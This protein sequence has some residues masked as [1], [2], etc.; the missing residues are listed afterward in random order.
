MKKASNREEPN[1]RPQEFFSA[2][3]HLTTV[4]QLLPKYYKPLIFFPRFAP[5]RPPVHWS[6]IRE[7]TSHG[8]VCPQTFPM[9][10]ANA[11]GSATRWIMFLRKLKPRLSYQSEDCLHLNIFVPKEGKNFLRRAICSNL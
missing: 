4:L 2:G 7:S 10:V 5:T 3:V 9:P 11:S 6:G 1:P 8:P